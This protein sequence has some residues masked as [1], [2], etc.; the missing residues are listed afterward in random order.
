VRRDSVVWLGVICSLVSGTG[1]EYGTSAAT[2]I[3]VHVALDPSPPI[4]GNADVTLMLADVN[5]SPVKDATVRLE[6]NMNHAGMRPS[7]ADL[8]EVEPGRYSGTI[9]FTM[10]GDWFILV[11]AKTLEGKTVERKIEVPGVKSS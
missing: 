4:V 2:D 5:G 8:R 1:C 11:T 3:Q 6:G 10:G 7:F 9:E